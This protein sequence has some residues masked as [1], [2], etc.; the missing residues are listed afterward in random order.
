MKVVEIETE[1]RLYELTCTYF[2]G[3]SRPTY[4]DPGDGGEVE[5]SN[6]VK[7]YVD[8]SQ[9]AEVTTYEVFLLDYAL[10]NGVSLE[11]AD[12]DVHDYVWENVAQQYADDYES[13]RETCYERD[14]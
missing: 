7:Y 13:S 14:F 3:G 2:H 8:S 12:R 1:D 11:Q 6:I 10:W 4:W 5:V 9:V